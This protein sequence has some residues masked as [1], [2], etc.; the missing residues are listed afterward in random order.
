VDADGDGVCDPGAVSDGPSACTGSDNCPGK[1]NPDQSDNEGDGLGD[2]CDSDDD[3]DL[4][5][6][7][8]DNCPVDANSA[9]AD[10][11]ADG[12][13]DACD[14]DD[15]NDGVADEKMSAPRHLWTW[16]MIRARVALS[17]SSARATGHRDRACPGVT[18]ANT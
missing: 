2:A 4:V 6:D 13:G 12:L 10:F 11:D 16:S 17:T 1:P 9:Q 15:D 8:E 7:D 3:N 5:L 14:P 18:T